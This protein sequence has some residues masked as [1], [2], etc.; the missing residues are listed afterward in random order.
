MRVLRYIHGNPAGDLSLDR[1]ADV[2]A[3][4]RFH[5]HRVFHAMTGETCA[6]A[7]RRLR[8]YRAA[9]YWLMHKDWPVAEVAA[10]AGYPNVNSFTRAFRDGFGVSPNVFR[11]EGC[12][13]NAQL[14]ATKGGFRL[15]DVEINETP[16]RRL[17]ALSHKGPYTGG[18]VRRSKTCRRPRGLIISGLIYAASSV[19]TTTIRTWSPTPICAAMPDWC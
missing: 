3:M 11:K 6:Q 14:D 12:L 19:S 10:Q 16:R 1:L 9:H 17:A 15:F 8:L 13:S 2:A 5:W 4:S 7:V 18:S